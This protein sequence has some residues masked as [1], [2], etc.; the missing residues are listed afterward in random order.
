MKYLLTE[1]EKHP[2]WMAS[3]YP[4][5]SGNRTRLL[6]SNRQIEQILRQKY[7]DGPSREAI[8]TARNE[9]LNM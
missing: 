9:L 3:A 7:K 6:Y 1:L 4:R 8:R 2:E 5:G